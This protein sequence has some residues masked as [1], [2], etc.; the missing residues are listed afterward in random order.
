MNQMDIEITF[1]ERFASLWHKTFV[2]E[3]G[4]M[5]E[6]YVKVD[7]VKP[8]D[9]LFDGDIEPDEEDEFSAIMAILNK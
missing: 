9:H 5:K 8:E 6:V 1:W 2:V 7:T 4:R 3:E